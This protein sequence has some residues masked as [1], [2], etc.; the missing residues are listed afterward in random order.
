MNP[1]SRTRLTLGIETAFKVVSVCVYAPEQ[2]LIVQR[3]E[4]WLERGHAEALMPILRN[5]MTNAGAS[6]DQITEIAVSVGPGSFTGTRIG[7]AAAKALG[8][9]LDVE[10]IGVSS[11]NAFAAPLFGDQGVSIASV[12]DAGEGRVFFQCFTSAG[13]ELNEPALISAT[14]AVRT[15]PTGEIFVTGTGAQALMLEAAK[16]GAQLT[17]AGRQDSPGADQIAILGARSGKRDVAPRPLYLSNS[18]TLAAIHQR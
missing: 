1:L 18:Y 3:Y 5:L 9:A 15:L 13:T 14:D 12:V 2:R 4:E 10:V 6:F 7:V 11:L 16:R 17:I 8:L